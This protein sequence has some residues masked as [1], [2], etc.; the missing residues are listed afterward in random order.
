VDSPLLKKAKGILIDFSLAVKDGPGFCRRE[1]IIVGTES[2]I[3]T[4]SIK[5]ESPIIYL[6]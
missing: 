1:D 5:S 6:P 2:Y 4:D 3:G